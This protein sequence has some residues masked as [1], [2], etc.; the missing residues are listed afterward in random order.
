MVCQYHIFNASATC[1]SSSLRLNLQW[2]KYLNQRPHVSF[3]NIQSN[4]DILDDLCIILYTF[5]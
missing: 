2:G 3:F 4:G 1:S 5:P